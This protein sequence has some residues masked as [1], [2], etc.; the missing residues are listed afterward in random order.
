MSQIIRE[1]TLIGDILKEWTIQEYEKYNRGI[2]W[3]II[4][5]GLGIFFVVYGVVTR[6]FLFSLIIILFAIILFLQAHQDP[7][8]I[9]FKIT[10]LGVVVGNRFYSFSELDSFFIIYNPPDVKTLFL[11]TKEVLKP[12]IRV[13]LLDMNPV[14]VKNVL[15]AYLPENFEREN[16]PLS[17][18]AARNWQIH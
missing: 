2:L 4:M 18:R 5:G 17:D 15:R 6:D 16:E 7:K 10:E 12:M 8:Q 3:Y 14:D 11:E 1:D 9:S 13:P